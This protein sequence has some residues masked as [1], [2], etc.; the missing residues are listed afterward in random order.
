MHPGCEVELNHTKRN[1]PVFHATVAQ[2]KTTSQRRSNAME[3]IL[4]KDI[5]NLYS[6]PGHSRFT[7]E[8]HI[9]V[10]VELNH[11]ENTSNPSR[12][13]Y[14]TCCPAHE[15]SR[16]WP[17]SRTRTTHPPTQSRHSNAARGRAALMLREDVRPWYNE[18]ASRAQFMVST[19]PAFDLVQRYLFRRGV[20]H[21]NSQALAV[22]RSSASG[23]AGISRCHHP[24]LLRKRSKTS[25]RSAK[26]SGINKRS[27]DK[28]GKPMA[29]HAKPT[30]LQSR[31]RK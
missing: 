14:P 9:L 18:Q 15:R 10:Q 20:G 12:I 13:M 11:Q 22:D 25:A 26:A 19:V 30:D 29:I 4:Q 5:A 1:L 7:R 24:V 3:D 8:G 2:R 27:V 31:V 21:P 6:P 28:T 17:W 16:E 23:G